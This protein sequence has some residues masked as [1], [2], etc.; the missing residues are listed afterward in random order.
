MSPFHIFTCLCLL[1]A[2]GPLSLPAAD[3]PLPDAK[4]VLQRLIEKAKTSDENDRLFD[5]RYSYTRT[6]TTE[7]RNSRGVVKKTDSKETRHLAGRPDPDSVAK[8]HTTNDTA[9]EE[10]EKATLDEDLF[11]HFK[12]TVTGRET[13]AGRPALKIVFVPNPDVKAGRSLAGRVMSRISGELWVDEAESALVRVKFR[14]TEPVNILA[15]IAGSLRAFSVQMD[16]ARTADGLWYDRQ[17]T[18]NVE[19]REF[20]STVVLEGREETSGVTLGPPPVG[21]VKPL[22]GRGNGTGDR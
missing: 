22:G 20:L 10:K 15:G 21:D 5:E 14:L 6:Q 12:F 13:I 11:K 16:C 8:E 17:T 4:T 1:C 3:A 18:W 2:A 7:H 19:A 9:E